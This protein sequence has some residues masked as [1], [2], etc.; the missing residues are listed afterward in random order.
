MT[1]LNFP[2][3]L[4]VFTVTWS[5]NHSN[6]LIWCSGSFSV[7]KTVVL[8]WFIF[9]I[10][11]WI[12]SS[13]EPHLFEI[14]ILCSIIN[15]FTVFLVNLFNASLLNK[16]FVFK[17]QNFFLL[18]P[19][20]DV[21]GKCKLVSEGFCILCNSLLDF[22]RKAKGIAHCRILILAGVLDQLMWPRLNT[23]YGRL[24]GQGRI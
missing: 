24:R 13:K 12:Q 15:V 7:L 22:C 14:E 6:M 2:Q 5:R 19:Y 3:P 9:G 10:L 20:T 21:N 8:L 23:I 17:L 18:F 4:L 11:W 1:K 16:L